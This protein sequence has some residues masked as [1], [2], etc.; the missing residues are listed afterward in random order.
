MLDAG[1]VQ[2]FVLIDNS[3]P[4]SSS[5]FIDQEYLGGVSQAGDHFGASVGYAGSN[6]GATYAVLLAGAPD[7]GAMPAGLVYAAP[8]RNG[9]EVQVP[10]PGIQ[11]WT[12]ASDGAR[13]GA[14]VGGTVT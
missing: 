3:P 13:Y 6:Y 1:A 5:I 12:P 7:D 8:R 9:P 10:A 11:V 2:E 14:A 4:F